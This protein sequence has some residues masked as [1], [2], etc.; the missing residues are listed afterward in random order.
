MKRVVPLTQFRALSEKGDFYHEVGICKINQIPLMSYA[1]SEVE[2]EVEDSPVL[3]VIA[4][5]AGHRHV[6]SDQGS[7]TSRGAAGLLIPT[8][9]RRIRCSHRAVVLAIEPAA[10]RRASASIQGCPNDAHLLRQSYERFPAQ[11]LTSLQVGALHALLRT[12]DDCLAVDPA[13]PEQL[14]LDDTVL[15]LVASFL[16]PSLHQNRSTDQQRITERSGRQAFDDLIDYILVNLDQPLR[17][18]DLEARSHYSARALQYAFRERLGSTPKQWIREQRLNQAFAQLQAESSAP[19]IRAVALRCGY[20]HMGR[21]S[22]DFKRRFGCS[23]SELA[24]QS[25]HGAEPP[26]DRSCR[27]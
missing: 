6:Q 7:I 15:R 22:R 9:N 12:L 11:Q 17:L 25:G 14:G 20:R 2:F 4:A 10:L 5:F 23:P 24:R 27:P 16:D 19:S 13:L 21:F 3:H 1:C 26:R 8:G 18:S